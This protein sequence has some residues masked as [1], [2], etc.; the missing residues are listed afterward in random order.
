MENYNENYNSTQVL[1]NTFVANVFMWMFAALGITA[2]TAYMFGTTPD[3][4]MSMFSVRADGS[5]S[6]NLLGWIVM[7]A[8]L[9]IVFVMSFGM[10]KMKAST[11]II[12]YLV[13]SVLMGMSL[14]FIFLAYTGASIAKTFVITAGMFGLMAFLGYTTKTDLTKMG[15]IL[16]M[17]L[18]GI[19]IA[20]VVNMFMHSESLDYIISIIGVIIFTGLTAYD[21]QKIKEI[22]MLGLDNNETM[23]KISI[24]A[25]LSLYLDFIN[26]FLYLL[27]FFGKRN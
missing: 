8:P 10:E 18:F 22:G 19:I 25:A 7:L 14:G 16:L 24:Q 17:G 3:L 23:T 12:L 15:S 5:A 11:M 6:L 26:L 9:I 4:M 13:Y 2:L 27:R 20:T 21:V 1:S